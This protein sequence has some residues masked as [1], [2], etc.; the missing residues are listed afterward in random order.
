MNI[1]LARKFIDKGIIKQGTLIEAYYDGL[2]LSGI[3][4]TRALGEFVV[5][6]AKVATDEI[7]FQTKG[8]GDSFLKIKSSDVV[9]ID[10]MEVSRV[11]ETYDLNEKDKISTQKRRGRKPK[12][13]R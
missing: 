9:K 1:D 8:D 5:L 3:K 2:S 11:V 12:Q 13:G 10:G 7:V 4:N 6:L